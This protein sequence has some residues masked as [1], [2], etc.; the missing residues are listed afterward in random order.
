MWFNGVSFGRKDCQLIQFILT[1]RIEGIPPFFP[2]Q[3][4]SPQK[5]LWI[6]ARQFFMGGGAMLRI[7]VCFLFIIPTGWLPL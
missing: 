1:I 5:E 2:S 7:Y 3:T 4:N 6:G